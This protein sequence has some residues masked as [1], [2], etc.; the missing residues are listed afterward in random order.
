MEPQA[1]EGSFSCGDRRVGWPFISGYLMCPKGFPGTSMT[2]VSSKH[3]LERQNP[4]PHAGEPESPFFP[5]KWTPRLIPMLGSVWGALSWRRLSPCSALI[6]SYLLQPSSYFLAG[7]CSG[8]TQ[9]SEVASILL[10]CILR[11]VKI[12]EMPWKQWPKSL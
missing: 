11:F 10:I 12:L 7:L 5:K 8:E 6:A 4:R 3:L 9:T 2:P 1:A